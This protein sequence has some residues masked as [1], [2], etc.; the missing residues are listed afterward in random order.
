MDDERRKG[1]PRTRTWKTG[2][3]RFRG[4]G[5]FH[6]NGVIDCQVANLSPTGARLQVA[7]QIGIPDDFVLWIEFDDVKVP[8]R[9][10]WRTAR[11]MG[12]EFNTQAQPGLAHA[13]ASSATSALFP[14]SSNSAGPLG[15][16][17]RSATAKP[18]WKVWA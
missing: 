14:T 8:C 1:H 9:V 15:Q 18:R 13:G 11:H 3:I 16:S 6:P 12:V 17:E 4:N 5:G 10:I 2:S 7:S